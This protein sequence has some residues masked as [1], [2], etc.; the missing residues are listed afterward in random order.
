MRREP[1]SQMPRRKPISP[2]VAPMYADSREPAASTSST[3]PGD[4]RSPAAT[5]TTAPT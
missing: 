4:A 2:T 3:L 5:N 1:S